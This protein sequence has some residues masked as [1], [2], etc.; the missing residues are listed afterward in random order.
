[1]GDQYVCYVRDVLMD[2]R[3]EWRDG[4]AAHLTLILNYFRQPIRDEPVFLR[5]PLD[6]GRSHRYVCRSNRNDKITVNQVS[7]PDQEY[8][9][10]FCR[11]NQRD[12]LLAVHSQG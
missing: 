12:R 9:I 4:D 6:N 2:Q 7:Q 8:E 10:I 3:G 5:A 1:M 11:E